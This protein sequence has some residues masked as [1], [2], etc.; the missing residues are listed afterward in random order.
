MEKLE[1]RKVELYDEIND[2]TITTE[3]YEMQDIIDKIN[4]I[5]ELINEITKK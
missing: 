1:K 4:E 3:N 2:K 5:I